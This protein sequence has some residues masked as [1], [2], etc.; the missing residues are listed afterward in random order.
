MHLAQDFLKKNFCSFS[1]HFQLSYFLGL[2]L[3]APDLEISWEV[4][5]SHNRELKIPVSGK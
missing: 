2:G 4:P 5:G 3:D 1:S